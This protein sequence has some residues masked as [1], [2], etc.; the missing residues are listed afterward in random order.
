MDVFIGCN[1]SQ[2][3][4]HSFK[5]SKRYKKAKTKTSHL[6]ENAPLIQTIQTIPNEEV[7]YTSSRMFVYRPY[8]YSKCDMFVK[9][10]VIFNR[11]V[12]LFFFQFT[13]VLLTL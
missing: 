8:A 5:H 3:C 10:R 7:I 2:C 9:C 4:L 6:P 12:T 13:D 11:E 1:L